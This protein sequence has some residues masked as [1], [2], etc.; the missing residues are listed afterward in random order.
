MNLIHKFFF[1]IKLLL[2]TAIK[3]YTYYLLTLIKA[4]FFNIKL[5]FDFYVLNLYAHF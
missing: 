4:V 5:N 2:L 3:F 1:C